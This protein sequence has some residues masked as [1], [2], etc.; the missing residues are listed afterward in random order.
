MS[1][2]RHHNRALTVGERTALARGY[3]AGNSDNAYASEDFDRARA[4]RSPRAHARVWWCGYVL[5]FFGSY[6]T[7]EVPARWRGLLLGA[8]RKCGAAARAQGIAA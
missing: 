6:E 8:Q 1:R 3:D 5:G 2:R 4:G 7:S